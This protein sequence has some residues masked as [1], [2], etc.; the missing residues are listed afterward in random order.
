[1]KDFNAKNTGNRIVINEAPYKT[2]VNLKRVLLNEIKNN[3][4]GLKISGDTA[5]V[6]EKSI[7]FTGCIDFIKNVLIGAETNIEIEN[8][9]NDCLSYCTYKTVEQI[10]PELFNKEPSAREDYYEIII[11]CVEENLKPFIK[12]LAS[13]WSALAPKLGESQILSAILAQTNK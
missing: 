10:T 12:S 2:V 11:S 8:A 5:N 4:I 13:E 6:L 3:S 7:D 1:M 9:I